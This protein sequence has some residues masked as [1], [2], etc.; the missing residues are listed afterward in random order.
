MTPECSIW[1]ACTGDEAVVRASDDSPPRSFRNR[2]VCESCLD[3]LE[4]DPTV[5]VEV[6]EH[7]STLSA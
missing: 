1:H 5:E 3:A 4:T 2:A 6:D 7:L